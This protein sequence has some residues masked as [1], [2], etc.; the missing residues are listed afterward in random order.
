MPY[1]EKAKRNPHQEGLDRVASTPMP[2]DQKY[3]IGARV[4]IADN[5][6]ATMS[7]FE[8]GCNATVLYTYGHAFGGN[9]K[10]YALDLDGK[11][12]RAWYYEE[13][14][15]LIEAQQRPRL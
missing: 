13:Q 9:G 5:L 7:H 14:L 2:E 3:P 15:T 11:G 10:S 4:R 12:F 6:G 8:N 1:V